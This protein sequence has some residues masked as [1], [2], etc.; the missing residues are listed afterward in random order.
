MTATRRPAWWGGREHK[1]FTFVVFIAIAT[2]DNAAG[3]VMKPLFLQLED[4]F[5]VDKSA[6]GGLAAAHFLATHFTAM[7]WGYLG[8]RGDRKRLLLV[9]TLLWSVCMASTGLATTFAA[10]ASFQ[11]GAAIG[12]GCIGSVGF[13]IVGD[14]IPPHRRGLALSLWVLAQAAG[15]GAGSLAGGTLGADLWSRP[16]LAVSAAGF[17][18][19]LLYP[20]TFSPGRGMAEPELAD[21]TEDGIAYEH[22]ISPRSLATMGSRR[23]NR[24]LLLQ[25]YLLALPYGAQF[26]LP[27]WAISKLEALG[28]GRVT[29]T[30]AA[31]VLIFLFN[32]GSL[33]IIPLGHLSDLVARRRMRDRPLMA[34]VGLLASFP[35]IVF[36]LFYPFTGVELPAI[37]DG[38][39]KGA[40]ARAAVWSVFTSGSLFLV[41]LAGFLSVVLAA[42]YAATVNPM[43]NDANL[44]EHRGTMFAAT[45]FAF[46]LGAAT[47]IVLTGAIVEPLTRWFPD[48]L[49][50]SV[51]YVLIYAVVLPSGL[52][53]VA[54]SRSL[55]GRRRGR[56]PD[57]GRPGPGGPRGRARGPGGARPGGAAV[58]DRPPP[59]EGPVDPVAGSGV[60]TGPD[61]LSGIPASH[62]DGPVP[63]SA[64]IGVVVNP[65]S[66]KNRRD[67]RD[68]AEEIRRLLGPWG[69]VHRTEGLEELRPAI[70]SLLDEGVDYFVSDG[71]DG[72]LHWM[73]N[74]LARARAERGDP[75]GSL[76]VVLPTNGGTID[77]VARKA[78]VRGH[79]F[80]IVGSLVERLAADRPPEV[81]EIDSL[82]ILEEGEDAEPVR[83]LGFAL[84]AG[85]VGR[86]FFDRYYEYPDP[87]A[88]S[89]VAIIVRAVASQVGGALRLPLPEPA[90]DYARQAFRRT[91]A[92]VRID[93]REVDT[94]EHGAINA[95]SID[96]CLGGVIRVFPLAVSEGEIHFQARGPLAVGRSSGTCPT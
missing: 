13:S 91:E 42:T 56:P 93:G 2:L 22:R 39:S 7:L 46:A 43:I 40:V 41:L 6:I 61:K 76:P 1:A 94:T 49:N 45:R 54:M 16:F 23:S 37:E 3:A 36:A 70:R 73:L 24:W 62:A 10:F 88:R 38:A 57:P 15:T 72:A 67:R 96:I 66:R 29:A 28:H 8:D 87:G 58:G 83:R 25:G 21:L 51:A 44:P 50:F 64:R 47:S 19:A 95:G 26:W 53:L 32:L 17:L 92:R 89:I 60:R 65:N 79:A 55:P 75:G 4:A 82:E 12:I 52:T 80:S 31:T 81:A 68:R 77:F 30:V 18:F 27:T 69:T 48:P 86:R 78:G 59:D 33:A 90:L 9:G 74:E 63:P 14:F 85:G 5:R 71:G 84:A 35:C 34:A 20:L 11:L